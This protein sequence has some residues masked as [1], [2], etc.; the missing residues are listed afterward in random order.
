[1]PANTF[2]PFGLQSFGHQD[3]SAPTMGMSKFTM[4]SSYATAVY[5]GDLV[6]FSSAARGVVVQ[7]STASAAE[8]PV[9]VF[10]GCEYYN[11][12]VNRVTWSPYFPGSVGSSSPVTAY[13]ISDPEMTFL[14]QTST[15]SV[16]GSSA[17]GSL[18]SWN[19]GTGNALTGQSG[20]YADGVT[21]LTSTITGNLRVVDAYSNFGPPGAN[22]TDTATSGQWLIVQPNGWVRN[23]VTVTGVTS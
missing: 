1:M 6:A 12:T 15:A 13:V 20:G 17:Q 3:G 7:F 23:T 22:G 4:N 14:V 5:N 16:I 9:G 10:V 18:V 21:G 2:A 11:P 19:A 8:P